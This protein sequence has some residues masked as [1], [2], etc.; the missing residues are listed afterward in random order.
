MAQAEERRRVRSRTGRMTG[1]IGR[2]GLKVP[3]EAP[4]DRRLTPRTDDGGGH[5]AGGGRWDGTHERAATVP[6]FPPPMA[7]LTESGPVC[8]RGR[9]G[10][11]VTP[12]VPPRRAPEAGP[13][14]A[15]PCPSPG[16]SCCA[17]SC[18]LA[19]SSSCEPA[20]SCQPA[21][22]PHLERGSPGSSCPRG[23]TDERSRRAPPAGLPKTGPGP[24]DGR[25]VDRDVGSLLTLARTRR[26]SVRG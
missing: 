20:G 13:I 10:A 18:S 15:Q 24:S 25:G 11:P 1:P 26:G 21:G 3:H 14:A 17:S 2:A 19:P 23:G 4:G 8:D 16:L 22:T 6:R 9:A 12:A 7:Y 5:S